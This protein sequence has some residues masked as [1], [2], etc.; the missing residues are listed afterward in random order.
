MSR[1]LD[2]FE[3][4]A[5][6]T[7]DYAAFNAVAVVRLAG[8]PGRDALR[9]A[10]D[11]FQ[12]RH[13]LLQMRIAG[14]RGSYRFE[15]APGARLPLQVG[16]ASSW[17]QVVE[18]A[19]NTPMPRESGPLARFTHLRAD[20][21]EPDRLVIDFHHSA[22]DDVAFV[23]FL[24]ELLELWA[25]VETGREPERSVLP[26]PS[27]SFPPAF[28]GLARLPRALAF[29][30]RQLRDEALYR[31]ASR[32]VARPRVDPNGRSRVLTRTLD[33][34]E[35]APL[36]E[37]AQR[38]GAT[39]YGTIAA[40]QL[41]AL[42]RVRYA[43][44]PGVLRHFVA[45]DLRPHL[46]PPMG[47]RLG[48]CIAFGLLAVSVDGRDFWELARDVS[49]KV[50]RSGRRGDPFLSAW[51]SPGVMWATTA[52]GRRLT[53]TALSYSRRLEPIRCE[54]PIEVLG[55]DTFVSHTPIGP[56]LSMFARWQ[57]GQL[58]LSAVYL[59]SDMQP[60]EAEA[61]ADDVVRRLAAGACPPT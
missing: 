46:R 1:P 8:A 50:R 54:G 41:G 52:L 24:P 29:G 44:R 2:P 20:G 11:R 4:A 49:E 61:L 40:A 59:D 7:G 51:A 31:L 32:R 28:R 58:S 30:S 47:A 36:R 55:V 48:A 13:P 6:W 15:P 45:W 9:H 22:V 33:R 27:A 19:L 56:E 25:G 57:A 34:R 12:Q 23:E 21:A 16:E 10:L 53:N 5:A 38:E 42:A 3:A 17:V 37:R 14:E 18:H 60:A 39:L 43:G 35:A 26:A